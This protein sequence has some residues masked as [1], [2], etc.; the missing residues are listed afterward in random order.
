MV[1]NMSFSRKLKTELSEIRTSECCKKAECYGF[2]LFGQSFNANKI[3]LLT[4][5]EFTAKRY[6]YLIRNCFSVFAKTIV[7]E[8]KR[9]TYKVFIESESDR[10]RIINMLGLPIIE[11]NT[12]INSNLILKNCCK[13]AFIRGM[14]LACGQAADPEREYRIDLRIKNPELAYAT[15]DLLYKR[16]LQPKITLKSLTNV[17]YLKKSECV[18][19]FLTL[20]GAAPATLKLMDIKAI[21]DFRSSINRKGNFEDAN[22]S[23]I[24]N[25]SVMQR[26]AIEYLIEKDKF[27][28][29]TDELQYAAKL[30]LENP[31]APL[32]ELCRLSSVPITRS[33]LNHRIRKIMEIAE[34]FKAKE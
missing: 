25:A 29:L 23:K 19:D 5:N 22:N 20:I 10:K 1:K 34:E 32:S 27:S 6:S 14:F 21:K 4:D 8:G 11:P 7:S 26:D 2:M 17:I 33:G 24:I 9:T 3:S 15:F 30:R 13:N 16:E 31:Y 12:A 28:A 18:E